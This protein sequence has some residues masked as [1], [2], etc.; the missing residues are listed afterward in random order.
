MAGRQLGVQRLP[1]A[2]AALL[3]HV[4]FAPQAERS[5]GALSSQPL[6]PVCTPLLRLR[7]AAVLDEGQELLTADGVAVDR[8]G[9]NLDLVRLQ[10]VVERESL[11]RAAESNSHGPE[12]QRTPRPLQRHR[13]PAPFATSQTECL[14]HVRRRL[15]FHPDRERYTLQTLLASVL[16]DA[17]R[18]AC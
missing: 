7:V 15:V 14:S 9:S 5:G 12:L 16:E 2:E 17:G 11:A 6:A 8:K 4:T 3:P 13:R 18:F 10:F 1:V